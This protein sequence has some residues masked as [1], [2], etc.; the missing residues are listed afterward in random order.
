MYKTETSYLKLLTLCEIL[1]LDFWKRLF[2]I[3]LKNI[4]KELL[5]VLLKF[6]MLECI[7]SHVDFDARQLPYIWRGWTFLESCCD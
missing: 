7:F 5:F 6:K 2:R 4:Q 3:N 1:N